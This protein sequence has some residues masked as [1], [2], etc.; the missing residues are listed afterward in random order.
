MHVRSGPRAVG[1]ALTLADPQKTEIMI[2]RTQIACAWWGRVPRQFQKYLLSQC[3]L[4]TDVRFEG[5]GAY[6]RLRIAHAAEM[7]IASIEPAT[8]VAR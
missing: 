1:D 8:R 4:K 2:L 3:G 6:E 5:L 7:L